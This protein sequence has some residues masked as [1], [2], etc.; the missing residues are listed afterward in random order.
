MERHFAAAYWSS[1]KESLEECTERA[2][3]F[4]RSLA[5]VSETLQGWRRKARSRKAALAQRVISTDNNDEIRMLLE[6][7]RNRRDMDRSVIEELGYSFALWNG[8]SGP[9]AADL[10]VGC[11]I[12]DVRGVSNAIVLNLPPSFDLSSG[13]SVLALTR[14]FVEAWEP[15]RFI[16]TT[17]NRNGEEVDK[18]RAK[19]MNSHPFLDVALYLQQPL[20]HSFKAEK[21]DAVYDLDH[22][23]V[24][25]NRTLSPAE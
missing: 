13:K 23:R 18:A 7:G 5:A 4:V 15:E 8:L 25:L 24:F 10:S 12:Y 20:A 2:S 1:R 3:N 16:L 19:G 22:G 11:G 14:S 17:S 6:K 9:N 21:G